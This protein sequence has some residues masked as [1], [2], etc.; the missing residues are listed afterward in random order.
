MANGLHWLVIYMNSSYSLKII[1]KLKF[2]PKHPKL[3][4]KLILFQQFQFKTSKKKMAENFKS[5]QLTF[6]KYYDF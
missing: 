2:G 3:T 5:C 6:I 4:D 1:I